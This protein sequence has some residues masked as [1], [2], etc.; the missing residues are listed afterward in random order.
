MNK[1]LFLVPAMIGLLSACTDDVPTVDDPHN[2]VISGQKVKQFEFLQ[3]YCVE[4]PANGTCLK[5]KNA[6]ALDSA[7]GEVPR[8]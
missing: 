4:N 8:F 6:M 2:I 3:T 5:V 1:I 7:K